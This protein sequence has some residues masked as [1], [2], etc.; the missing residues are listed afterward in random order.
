MSP[1]TVSGTGASVV[2]TITA[3]PPSPP[4]SGT[5]PT[6]AEL[7]FTPCAPKDVPARPIIPGTVEVAEQDHVVVF[8][9][10]VEALAPG[11]DEV[12]PVLAAERRPGDADAGVA[13][14]DR[15]ADEVGEVA[16]LG[17][18]G[19]DQRDAPL[20][21]DRRRA[22]LVDLLLDVPGEH[23][24]EGVQAERARV[25]LG[26]AAEEL[27]LDALDR[28]ALGEA[29][30][31]PAEAA[32]ER[33]ERPED[34][35]ILGG[36]GRDVDGGRDRAPGQRGDDLLGGLVAGAVGASAVEAPRCG[37]TITLG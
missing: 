6:A 16:R 1:S 36:D 20:A 12:R 10:H 18:L 15:D 11:L 13:R 27:D 22:D 5:W 14:D 24:D 17:A 32:A 30:R 33:Q 29:H 34:L 7:M 9:L 28:R 4:S 8:E 26:D 35:E 2:R 31:Q 25:A 19:L 21:G 23:A 3:T 37:V